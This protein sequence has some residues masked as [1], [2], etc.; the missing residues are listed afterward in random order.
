MSTHVAAAQLAP[1][2][3]DREATL[4]KALDAVAEAARGGAELV[5]FPES[6]LP[7]YPYWAVALD[8]MSNNGPMR[9]L[10]AQ[11]VRIDSDAEITFHAALLSRERVDAMKVFRPIYAVGCPLGN[12]PIPTRG[13]IA[14]LSHHGDPA[15]REST[16]TH[17]YRRRRLSRNMAALSR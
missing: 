17:R 13:E 4:A 10:Y 2:F 6:F 7:G 14:D 16:P 5:A 12:D 8:P 3:M 11:A 15:G 9:A 1:V